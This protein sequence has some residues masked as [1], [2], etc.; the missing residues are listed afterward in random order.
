MPVILQFFPQ[1]HH[2]EVLKLF[3]LDN[4]LQIEVIQITE[5]LVVQTTDPPS[6]SV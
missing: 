6:K 5:E 3:M 2:V 4:L 1:P